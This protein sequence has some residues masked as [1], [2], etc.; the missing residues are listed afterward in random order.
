MHQ[1]FN[2]FKTIISIIHHPFMIYINVPQLFHLLGYFR[3]VTVSFPFGLLICGFTDISYNLASYGFETENINLKEL[4]NQS[5][6]YMHKSCQYMNLHGARRQEQISSK[7]SEDRLHGKNLNHSRS[8]SVPVFYLSLT[9]FYKSYSS[10][11]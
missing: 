6:F 10:H 3:W 11:K 1:Y 5:S 8:S 2:L 4:T 7:T 9:P